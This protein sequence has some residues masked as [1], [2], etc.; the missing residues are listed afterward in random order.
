ML[1]KVL[2]IIAHIILLSPFA[3]FVYALRIGAPSWAAAGYMLGNAGYAFIFLLPFRRRVEWVRKYS[4]RKQIFMAVLLWVA[5]T[6][7]MNLP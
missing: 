6:V 7:L 4:L 1:N 3:A 5:G 2:N